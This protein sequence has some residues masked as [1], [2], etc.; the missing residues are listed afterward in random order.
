MHKLD[1]HGVDS[2]EGAAQSI[3]DR[4]KNGAYI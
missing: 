4:A 2:P 3:V 1:S